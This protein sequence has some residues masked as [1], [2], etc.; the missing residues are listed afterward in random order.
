M[1]FRYTQNAG[2]AGKHAPVA[3][4]EIVGLVRSVPRWIRRISRRTE[5]PRPAHATPLSSSVEE[6]T[7]QMPPVQAEAEIGSLMPVPK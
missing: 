1:L 3:V 4:R 5:P 6:P 2:V 7:F